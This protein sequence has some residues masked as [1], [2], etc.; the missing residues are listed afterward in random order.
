MVTRPW[1]CGVASY[2]WVACSRWSV[3]SRRE[4]RTLALGTT[5]APETLTSR[6]VATGL[7][8][9]WDMTWGPDGWLWVTERTTFRVTR[10]DP[11]D[12]TLHV[13]LV[14]DDVYQSVDQDGLPGAP[15]RRDGRGYVYANWSA[16]SPTPYRSLTFNN[17]NPP[18][19][20]PRQQELAWQHPDFVPPLATLFTVAADYDFARFGS[21]TVAPSGIDVYTA[22]A[23]P[24]W[25]RS[26]LMAAMRSGAVYRLK[27]TADGRAVSGAPVEYFKTTNRYRDIASSPDGRRI[28]ISTDDH[29]ITQDDG[30]QRSNRLANPGAILEFTYAPQAPGPPRER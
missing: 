19:S 18:V 26:L 29:G 23:I 5:P 10:I 3:E 20:V 27:L 12:G 30:G 25:T 7:G 1:S 9:P 22:S 13:A 15:S 2:W 17:R 14:L 16:S 21:A 28:F 8:N 11:A 4:R 24:G 6:V